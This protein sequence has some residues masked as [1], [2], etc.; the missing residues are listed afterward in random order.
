MVKDDD[1]AITNEGKLA[2]SIKFNIHNSYLWV[3]DNL[4]GRKSDAFGYTTTQSSLDETPNLQR[5]TPHTDDN[6]NK[7][8]LNLSLLNEDCTDVFSAVLLN[9]LKSIIQAI[10]NV[11]NLLN[12]LHKETSVENKILPLCGSFQ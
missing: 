8:L 11:K 1:E 4:D 5:S 7:E 9:H 10:P 3:H 12:E 2:H 6:Q